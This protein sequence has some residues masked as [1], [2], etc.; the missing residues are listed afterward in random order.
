MTKKAQIIAFY[1]PQY[2]PIPENDT[3][4][5]K[6]FTEWTNVGKAQPLFRNHYQPRVPADL[7]YYDLRMPEVREAQA[8]LAR[9]AGVAAFCY[10][11]YWFGNGKQLLEKPLKDVVRLGKPDFPFCLAWANHSWERKD[12]NANT[13]QLNKELLIRQEYP[14]TQD[15][16]AHFYAMLPAF[17]DR[18][19]YQAKGKLLFLLYQVRHIPYLKQFIERWQELAAEN[20]LPGFY[21]VAQGVAV[22][23]LEDPAYQLCD[24]VNLT[25]R[26]NAF[27]KNLQIRRAK[28]LASLL[29]RRPLHIVD[30]RKAIRAYRDPVMQRQWVYPTI[31]PNWDHSPRSGNAAMIM[32]NSRPEYFR[33]HVRE[34]L[35]LIQTKPEDDRLVFLKSWNEWAEGNYMEPDLQ[36]GKG[37]IHAL[38]EAL[39]D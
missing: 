20:G 9:E 2:H 35:E 15:I 26:M 24:G 5:G 29:L 32:H 10:W 23:D 4:W 11:H 12:W 39:T 27:G 38:R 18:R 30:Y 28:T 19:Y 1:L 8:E 37:Y 21:F 25:L 16:D 34:I 3:W 7:G 6:G 31:L 36:F 13:N 33:D 22:N 14:G 17:Q